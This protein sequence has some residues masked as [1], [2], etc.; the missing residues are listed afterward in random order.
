[1]TGLKPSLQT[2]RRERDR[3]RPGHPHSVETERLGA[4]DKSLLESVV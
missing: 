4:L 2:L 3:I 1:M